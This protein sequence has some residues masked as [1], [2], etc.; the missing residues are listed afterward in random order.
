[1]IRYEK[2][3][4]CGFNKLIDFVLYKN[5]NGIFTLI[6]NGKSIKAEF[7]L[8]LKLTTGFILK[9]MTLVMKNLMQSILKI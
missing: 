6:Y 7:I 1:M 5:K 4:K 9:K 8:Y 2:E 3:I